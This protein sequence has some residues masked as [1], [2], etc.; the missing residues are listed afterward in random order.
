MAGNC[1]GAPAPWAG[2]WPDFPRWPRH[3]IF[4]NPHPPI[5]RVSTDEERLVLAIV[6][7]V[8]DREFNVRELWAH[9]KKVDG[10]L[11]AAFKDMKIS[12][13]VKLG[14]RLK[15]IEGRVFDGFSIEWLGSDRGHV[16]LWR[17]RVR[18]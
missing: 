9:A 14:V 2:R 8:G 17:A 5:V 6:D 7:H 16:S 18:K 15:T 4:V 1:K 3:A 10:A 12:S 13:P 11:R